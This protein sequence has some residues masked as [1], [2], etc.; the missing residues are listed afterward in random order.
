MVEVRYVDIV[1][2]VRV[3]QSVDFVSDDLALAGTMTMTW[4]VQ[5]AEGGT[6]VEITAEDV[7]DGISAEDHATGLAS[8]LDNPA[9]HLRS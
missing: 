1:P 3:V 5:A 7:P 4:E 8:S 9:R 6:L 2:D